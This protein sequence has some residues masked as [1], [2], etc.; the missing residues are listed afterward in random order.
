MNNFMSLLPLA[1]NTAQKGGESVNPLMQF[2]PILVIF[3]IMYMLLIR[4]QQKKNKEHKE[5]IKKIK[6]GDKVVTAGGI[7]GTINTVEEDTV[8]LDVDDGQLRLA[9]SSV[10]KVNPTEDSQ[11]QKL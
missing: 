6:S 3:V 1:Q 4:P 10:V 5:L 8:L 11:K 9:R 7:H 2:F